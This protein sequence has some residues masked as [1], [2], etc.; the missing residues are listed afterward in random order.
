MRKRT[1][2]EQPGPKMRECNHRPFAALHARSGRALTLVARPSKPARGPAAAMARPANGP[3]DFTLPVQDSTMAGWPASPN[4]FL[5]H[6]PSDD[7]AG[8][9]RLGCRRAVGKA[10]PRG[11]PRASDTHA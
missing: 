5:A 9:L 7:A 2:N 3:Q 8:P 11:V 10:A 4:A 6:A 1:R